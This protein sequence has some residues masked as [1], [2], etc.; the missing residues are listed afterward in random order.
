MDETIFCDEH[1]RLDTRLFG[2]PIC[3]EARAIKA[4]AESARLREALDTLHDCARGVKLDDC[5]TCAAL[6]LEA[7]VEKET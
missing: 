5:A 4:E 7:P 2:C 6:A 3:S 1:S